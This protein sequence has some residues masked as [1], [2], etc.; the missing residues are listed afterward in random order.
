[1]PSLPNNAMM[2]ACWAMLQQSVGTQNGR[3]HVPQPLSK[4]LC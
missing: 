4:P 3:Q 1:L 2:A